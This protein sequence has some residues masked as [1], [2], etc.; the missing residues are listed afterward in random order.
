MPPPGYVMRNR[1]MLKDIRIPSVGDVHV[2][3]SEVF[4]VHEQSHKV[5]HAR[6]VLNSSTTARSTLQRH[7]TFNTLHAISP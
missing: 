5:F 6:E 7:I 3:Q 4:G 1:W 2:S